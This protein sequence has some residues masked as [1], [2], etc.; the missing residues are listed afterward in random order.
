MLTK[1]FKVM[2]SAGMHARPAAILSKLAMGYSEDIDIKYNQK[3]SSM[4]SIMAI[5][6]LGI[7]YTDEFEVIVSGDNVSSTMNMIEI[8]LKENGIIE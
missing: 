4:K 8:V 5:M 1:S 2:D 3:I 6:A 7:K